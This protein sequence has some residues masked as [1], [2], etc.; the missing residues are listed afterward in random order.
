MKNRKEW[1]KEYQL[2]FLYLKDECGARKLSKGEINKM[3]ARLWGVPLSVIKELE[4]ESKVE[5]NQ[6]EK[7]CTLCEY[8]GD[9]APCDKCYYSIGN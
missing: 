8:L 3:L 1:V 4:K 5:L 2:D 7:K 6:D 9:I